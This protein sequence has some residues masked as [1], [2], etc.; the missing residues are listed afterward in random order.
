[1]VDHLD[2]TFTV[3]KYILLLE[4]GMMNLIEF[5]SKNSRVNIK[6]GLFSVSR[7]SGSR[8]SE[9]ILILM[10]ANENRKLSN[11]NEFFHKTSLKTDGDTLKIYFF[12]HFSLV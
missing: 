5:F 10:L 4:R 7:F 2:S 9:N 3:E 1:M 12:R 6:P 8:N 11:R